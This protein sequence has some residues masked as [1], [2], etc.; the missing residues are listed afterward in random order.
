MPQHPLRMT[1]AEAERKLFI[2][3]VNS[4]PPLRVEIQPSL[5]APAPIEP[6][7]PVAAIKAAPDASLREAA[8]VRRRS[9]GTPNRPPPAP[10]PHPVV[11]PPHPTRH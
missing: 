5:A 11:I 2:D 3:I 4:P 1:T 10:I 6:Q 8:V 7:P 9:K